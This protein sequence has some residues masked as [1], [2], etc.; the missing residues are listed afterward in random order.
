MSNRLTGGGEQ[1]RFSVVAQ[2][3]ELLQYA[4]NL[5][6]LLAQD[7]SRFGL[8]VDRQIQFALLPRL[9]GTRVS[10]EPAL[11]DLL[12]LCLDGPSAPLPLV[13][14]ATF[15]RAHAAAHG[16]TSLDGARRA[17]FPGAARALSLALA[18]VR[19]VGVYPRPLLKNA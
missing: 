12:I 16:G 2:G 18:T 10:L 3:S 13:D 4:D 7:A 19:E 17:A 5:R 11:W 1:A 15:T 6:A 8:M 9:A 14:D